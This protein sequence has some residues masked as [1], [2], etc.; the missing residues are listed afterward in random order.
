[1]IVLHYFFVF[2]DWIIFHDKSVSGSHSNTIFGNKEERD[3]AND[4]GTKTLSII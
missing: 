1:M 2:S 3:G 4:A